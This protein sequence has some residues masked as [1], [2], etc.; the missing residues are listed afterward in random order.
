[1]RNNTKYVE[2]EALK[3]KLRDFYKANI[4]N[5]LFEIDELLGQDVKDSFLRR[6][7]EIETEQKELIQL[8]TK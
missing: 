7:A 4:Q 5:N 2:L 1:M 3:T 8:N 6:I